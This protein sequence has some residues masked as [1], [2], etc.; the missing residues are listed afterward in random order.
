MRYYG[1]VIDSLRTW[2]LGAGNFC[3]NAP[4]I[5]SGW[6]LSLIDKMLCHPRR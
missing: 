5:I 4:E 1:V 2:G 3:I 6:M